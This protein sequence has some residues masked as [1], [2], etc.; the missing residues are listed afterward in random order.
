MTKM[1]LVPALK[2]WAIIIRPFH[3]LRFVLLP[4][5]AMNRWAIFSRPRTRTESKHFLCK[6]VGHFPLVLLS[7]FSQIVWS[8]F[9]SS[10][11]GGNR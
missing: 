3:G 5:P 6:A 7:V 4:I 10:A 1:Q 11:I 2:C 9:G 8:Y